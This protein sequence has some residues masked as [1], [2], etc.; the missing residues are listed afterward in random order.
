[1]PQLHSYSNPQP[2]GNCLPFFYQVWPAKNK[3]VRLKIPSEVSYIQLPIS[4]GVSSSKTAEKSG[5]SYFFQIHRKVPSGE[6]D[7]V[8]DIYLSK[9]RIVSTGVYPKEITLT[10]DQSTFMLQTMRQGGSVTMVV[11]SFRLTHQ[12]RQS[13]NGC[14]MGM[15]TD[16]NYFRQPCLSQTQIPQYKHKK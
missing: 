9:I 13:K 12:L 3:H 16:E 1:M 11:T 8:L 15:T 10:L 14:T 7:S 5:F 4:S 2:H 6:K